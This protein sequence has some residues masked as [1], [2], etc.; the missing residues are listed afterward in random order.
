VRVPPELLANWGTRAAG[1]LIDISPVLVVSFVLIGIAIAVQDLTLFIVADLVI[2]IR[3]RPGV[4]HRL[5]LAAVGRPEADVRRQ[6]HVHGRHQGLT[7]VRG[8]DTAR[9]RGV[10]VRVRGSRPCAGR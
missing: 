7:P 6:D 5:S 10:G 3:T 9:S 8:P 2:V 4:R 1:L